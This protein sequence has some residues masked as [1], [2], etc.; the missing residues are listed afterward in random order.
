MTIACHWRPQRFAPRRAVTPCLHASKPP[1]A[2][3]K[4]AASAH[5]A[6]P[7]TNRISAPPICGCENAGRL[8]GLRGRPVTFTGRPS[9]EDRPGFARGRRLLPQAFTVECLACRACGNRV[10][11]TLRV[12]K[13]GERRRNVRYAPYPDEASSR[14]TPAGELPRWQELAR[15]PGDRGSLHG[16]GQ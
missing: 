7:R 1:T 6:M 10:M 5:A 9:R 3:V 15:S 8:T 2:R 4:I 16:P 13:L 12:V 11:N 14:I